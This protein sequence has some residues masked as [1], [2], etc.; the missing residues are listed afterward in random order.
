KRYIRCTAA[1]ACT[2]AGNVLNLVQNA[3]IHE[4][5]V[6]NYAARVADKLVVPILLSAGACF[7]ITG[8][9]TRTLSMLIFDFATGLRIA[10]PT[11]V[12]ASMQRAARRGILIKSG[13]ALE[14]LA[15]VDAVLFDKTGTLTTGEPHVT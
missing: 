7:A 12:L 11:A 3:P 5:R 13:G 2:R 8:N 10:A 14:R 15:G 6:E 4:T 9:V 1:G